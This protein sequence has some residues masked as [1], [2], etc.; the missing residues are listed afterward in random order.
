MSRYIVIS[1]LSTKRYHI[2]SRGVGI[3]YIQPST[4]EILEYTP[5]MYL[6][7]DEHID[8]VSLEK[9]VPQFSTDN[10]YLGIGE[11]HVSVCQIPRP[12]QGENE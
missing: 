11:T 1:N 6:N 2:K 10:L 5:C 12:R 7:D 4:T 8:S 9:I 3:R